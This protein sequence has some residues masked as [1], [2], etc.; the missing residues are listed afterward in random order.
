MCDN[1]NGW[2]NYPTWNI[3]LWI[4]NDEG[5]YDE[6]RRIVRRAVDEYTAEQ[7]LKELVESCDPLADKAN[8]YS[9]LLTWAMSKVDYREIVKHYKDEEEE[10]K[11]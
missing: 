8:M 1:Y 3:A 6:A 10:E 11:E 4:D 5:L 2:S 9:D 7:G